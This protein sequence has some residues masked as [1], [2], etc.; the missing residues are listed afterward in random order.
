[1]LRQTYNFYFSKDKVF[2]RQV[3]MITGFVP[4]EIFLY[5]LA[6][7]HSSL[8]TSRKQ[9]AKECNERLEFLGDTVLDSVISEY[10]FKL[11]PYKGE[12]FLTEMRSKIV[13]RQSLN[14]ICHK[15]HLSSLIQFNQSRKGQVNKS[16]YGDALEAFIGAVY[17]DL[18]FGKTKQFVLDKI[19][20]D[21]IDIDSVEGKIFN[22]KSMLLEHVQKEKLESLSYELVSETGDGKNKNFIVQVK[23]G[24]KVMG[25]GKGV[26]KKK[27]EQVAS[28]DALIKMNLLEPSPQNNTKKRGPS[29]P[30][31][32][33]V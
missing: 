29:K 25:K 31:K 20:G 13:N 8:V 28:E 10:L 18:G 15:I 9:S 7:K 3:K 11:Y 33:Q 4:K 19:V 26:R 17:L 12:G 16:M 22:Y 32:R 5:K 21:Q 27:A 6:L 30:R 24:S 2:V 23:I 14:E 1:M